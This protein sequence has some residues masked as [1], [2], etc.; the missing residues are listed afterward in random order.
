[1]KT[2]WNRLILLVLLAALVGGSVHLVQAQGGISSESPVEGTV[3]TILFIT[4]S[5]F[6]EKR[7]EVLIREEKCQFLDGSDTQISCVVHKPQ[8]PGK[9]TITILLQG[10][11]KPPSQ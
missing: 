9:Y 4:G 2:I 5:D 11:K 8:P 1:M 7:R 6:G 3:G 10:E